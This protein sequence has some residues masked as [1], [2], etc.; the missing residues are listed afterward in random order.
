MRVFIFSVLCFISLTIFNCSQSSTPNA[1]NKVTANQELKE[2]IIY[3]SGTCHYCVDT[4]TYLTKQN[5]PFVFYDLD[6]QPKK[7]EEMYSKLRKANIST[8]NFQI[9]V[10]DKS[11]TIITNDY[12]T[13]DT[14]LSKL[15]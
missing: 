13:F 9:P 12:L 3:G 10:V 6:L 1:G 4:K 8:A 2:L 14:F 11:G 5:I 15:H 7:I